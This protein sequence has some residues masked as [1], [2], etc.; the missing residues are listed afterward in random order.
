MASLSA[1]LS[2]GHLRFS[3]GKRKVSVPRTCQIPPPVAAQLQAHARSGRKTVLHMP[4]SCPTRPTEISS[5]PINGSVAGVRRI[6]QSAE[7]A[8]W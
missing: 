5:V 7:V 2:D 8:G 6:T 4:T 1:T 3:V